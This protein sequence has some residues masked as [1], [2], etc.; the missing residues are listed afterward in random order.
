VEREANYLAVGSFVLLVLVMGVLF[1][2]WYSDSREHHDYARYEIYFDGSI[3]GLSEGGP[4]RYLGVDVGR[5]ERIV[6]DPRAANRVQ[7]VADIDATTPISPQTLAQLSLQG[8]TGVL[9]IDLRQE[10][11]TDNARRIL[12]AVPSER[13]PVI[14]S[15]HSDLDSLLSSLPSLAAHLN[16][17]V[18]RGSEVLSDANIRSLNRIVGN[19]DKATAGLP[20]SARELDNLLASLQTSTQEARSLISEIHGP[21]VS[22]ST[23]LLAVVQKLRATGDN[24][25]RA[26][27]KLDAFI[28]DNRGEL[29]G[30]VQQTLP[31]VEALLR[32]SREAAQQIRELSSSL[33]ENPS[34]L[35]YQAPV[36][37]VSIPP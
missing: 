31:Q 25:E 24:L 20:S 30:F 36:S 26:S 37:G 3:S 18:D 32:D 1:V 8:V 28:S 5:V 16:E 15:E 27:G 19:L 13:Y 33:R 11:E 2:Y 10:R 29:S 23:E 22:A 9:Y 21:A 4:V 6:I 35:I 34:R 7:V 12:A 17:L 14:R